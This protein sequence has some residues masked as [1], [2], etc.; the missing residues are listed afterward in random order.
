M[1]LH[2]SEIDK[3]V[4]TDHHII[5]S[6]KRVLE[7][8]NQRLPQYSHPEWKE[9]ILPLREKQPVED[10]EK[11]TLARFWIVSRRQCPTIPSW[12]PT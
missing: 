4:L 6:A 3:N 7:L 8:L 1:T 11:L 12:P 9:H 2:R 10:G 5:G